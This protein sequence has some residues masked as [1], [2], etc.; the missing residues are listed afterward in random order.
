MSTRIT[1]SMVSQQVL[2]DV[3]DVSYRLSKTQEK[4][5][6]GKELTRPSDDPFQTSRALALSSALEGTQQYQRNVNDAQA[7]QQV[8]ETALS[9]IGD[10]AQRA[11]ELLV[12]AGN[13][14]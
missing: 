11:R 10:A 4:L 6:S 3:Q 2:Q 5:A 14:T 12:Q 1:N 9:S 7:W 8:T 13:D